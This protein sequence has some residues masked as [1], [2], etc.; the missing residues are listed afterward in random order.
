MQNVMWSSMQ[1]AKPL[2]NSFQTLTYLRK[3]VTCV[4]AIESKLYKKSLWH[5]KK[6]NAYSCILIK[7]VDTSERCTFIE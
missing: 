1:W 3:R 5:P 2:R 7:L 4:I 6:K